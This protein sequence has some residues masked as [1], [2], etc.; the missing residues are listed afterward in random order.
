MAQLALQLQRKEQEQLKMQALVVLKAAVV[1]LWQ[2]AWRQ[3]TDFVCLQALAV[4][5]ASGCH[6]QKLTKAA[7]LAEQAATAVWGFQLA[8]Q[9][10]S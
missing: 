2:Q 10:L 6:Q 1:L 4:V 5:Y 9:L 3:K 8:G 7:H